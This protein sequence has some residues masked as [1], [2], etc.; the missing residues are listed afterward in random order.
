[1]A[2]SPLSPVGPPGGGGRARCGLTSPLGIWGAAA[3]SLY[4]S[5]VG[6]FQSIHGLASFQVGM[7]NLSL[8]PWKLRNGLGDD[9]SRK[10]EEH[11]PEREGG[12]LQ[13]GMGWDSLSF[14]L[15]F[16]LSSVFDGL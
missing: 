1:M 2:Q 9:A 16:L 12:E 13:E 3:L 8:Q 10:L 6:R 4:C 15:F 11:A 7:T 5:K 14:L